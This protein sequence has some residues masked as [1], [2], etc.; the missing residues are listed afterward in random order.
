MIYHGLTI[1]ST[2]IGY[3]R[4]C[5]VKLDNLDY[6]TMI[7]HGQAMTMFDHDIMMAC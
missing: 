5:F 4:S 2:M 6:V 7:N 3:D 1:K